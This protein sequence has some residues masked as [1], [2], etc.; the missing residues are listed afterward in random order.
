LK[1]EATELIQNQTILP[2]I[3]L[4]NANSPRAAAIPRATKPRGGQPMEWLDSSPPPKAAHEVPSEKRPHFSQVHAAAAHTDYPHRPPPAPA[5]QPLH[6]NNK[7][8]SR[9][10]STR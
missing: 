2:R 6:N 7:K 9:V 3:I 4:Q 10:F 1:I 8:L 5:S